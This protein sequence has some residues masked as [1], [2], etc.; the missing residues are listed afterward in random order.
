MTLI[1]SDKGFYTLNF[2]KGEE[3]VSGLLEFLK[4]ENI[5]A[6]HITGL[7]AASKVT[8]AYYNLET[9]EYEKKT[10]LE[11]VEILSLTGNTGVKEGG[12]LVLHLHGVFGR[13]DFSAFGG[14]IF[15][16]TIS[17]AGEIHIA[18]FA[19]KIHRAYDVE[20]GLTLMCPEQQPEQ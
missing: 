15:E 10:I 12:E 6:A 13:R 14:H 17:G 3:V 1:H 2:K 9:K 20:S 16:M 5:H 8:I 11:D 19:G 7:G 4:K 18:S